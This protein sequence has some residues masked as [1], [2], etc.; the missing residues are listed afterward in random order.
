[1]NTALTRDEELYGGILR[2]VDTIRYYRLPTCNCSKTEAYIENH[3]YD[4]YGLDCRRL[5]T[6]QK[7]IEGN[8]FRHDIDGQILVVLTLGY[9]IY[10]L[11][12]EDGRCAAM[13]IGPPERNSSTWH[14]RFIYTA[15]EGKDLSD[16]TGLGKSFEEA[17][18]DLF[19]KFDARLRKINHPDTIEG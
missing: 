10:G 1:M 18:H 9:A 17:L 11:N 3:D 13:E 6:W 4:K 5:Q 16:R 8:F 15:A 14:A 2:L 19:V 7:L 12:P